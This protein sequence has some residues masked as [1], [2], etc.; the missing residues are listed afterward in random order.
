MAAAILR[1]EANPQVQ[2]SLGDSRLTGKPAVSADGRRIA[3]FSNALSNSQGERTLFVRDMAGTQYRQATLS[4]LNGTP[5]LSPDGEWLAYGSMGSIFKIRASGGEPVRLC[6]GLRVCEWSR[7]GEILILSVGGDSGIARV[8]AEGGEPKILIPSSAA[9]F[10]GCQTLPG[11]KWILCNTTSSS[12][13]HA[14]KG[15]G[16][17]RMLLDRCRDTLYVASGH[18]VFWRD[19]VA[20]VMAFDPASARTAGPEIVLPPP[21][22]GATYLMVTTRALP[23]RWI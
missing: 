12:S 3:Y 23:S 19:N 8:S 11:G 17:T 6:K 20:H 18:L 13:V 22:G 7:S 5:V 2:A 10:V 14:L 21:L 16:E 1:N 15:S 9:V 4:A